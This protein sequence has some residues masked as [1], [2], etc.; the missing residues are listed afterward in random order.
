VEGIRI[1]GKKYRTPSL[2]DSSYLQEVKDKTSVAIFQEN[3]TIINCTNASYEQV[4]KYFKPIL[5]ERSF[6]KEFNGKNAP[7]TWWIGLS[8]F[9]LRSPN[10]VFHYNRQLK[11]P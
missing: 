7:I 5:A 6:Y 3:I 4:K 1:F 2:Y 8:P 11:N 9:L 10:K